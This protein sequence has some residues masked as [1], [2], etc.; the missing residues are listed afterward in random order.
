MNATTMKRNKWFWPWQDEKEEIWLGEMSREGWHL[1]SVRLL[2]CYT[3]EKGDPASYVYRLDFFLSEKSTFPEYLQIFQDAGWEYLGELSNWRYWRK[4]AAGSES[5]EIYTDRESKLKKY[6]RLLGFMAFFL[7]FLIFMGSNL[8]RNGLRFDMDTPGWIT[9]IYTVAVG[10][11]AVIIPVYL[12]IVIK[13]LAR[14]N[15]LKKT[16]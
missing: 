8:F 6:K 15:Q 4:L 11:Y 12:V 3:F 14:M 10:A 9:A 5:P 13:I 2:C 7:F 1:Q 16:M